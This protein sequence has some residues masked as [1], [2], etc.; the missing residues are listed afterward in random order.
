MNSVGGRTAYGT[1]QNIHPRH[2]LFPCITL[3]PLLSYSFSL[4]LI[5]SL[6]ILVLIIVVLFLLIM[7]R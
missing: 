2:R 4:W 3:F 7:M 6:S 5:T 1:C